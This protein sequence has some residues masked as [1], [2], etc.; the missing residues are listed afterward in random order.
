MAASLASRLGAGETAQAG[1]Q[2]MVAGA[3]LLLRGRSSRATPELRR[4]E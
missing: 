4:L 3:P 2:V 1:S